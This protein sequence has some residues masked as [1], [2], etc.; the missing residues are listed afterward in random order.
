MAQGTLN[1]Q[2]ACD[3]AAKN[4]KITYIHSDKEEVILFTDELMPGTGDLPIHY[5]QITSVLPRTINHT[6]VSD[7]PTLVKK[8]HPTGVIAESVEAFGKL[9]A[10][11][12]QPKPEAQGR[13]RPVEDSNP[14]PTDIDLANELAGM[15]F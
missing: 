1:Y 15:D 7:L 8:R 9:R 14:V 12:N 3:Y 2:Q 4:G 5:V 11:A 6:L 13:Y 10:M